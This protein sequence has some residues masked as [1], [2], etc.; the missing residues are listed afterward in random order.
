MEFRTCNERYWAVRSGIFD[1][2][3]GLTLT[4]SKV[5]AKSII[6]LWI[7][8]TRLYVRGTKP[9]I[10]T[11]TGQ[12]SNTSKSSMIWQHC[13]DNLTNQDSFDQVHL[14]PVCKVLKITQGAMSTTSSA[15][16]KA[17]CPNEFCRRFK[18]VKLIEVLPPRCFSWNKVMLSWILTPSC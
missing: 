9:E 2:L 14:T 11:W 8:A 16:Q 15:P 17:L 13:Y 12:N 5:E 4:S 3:S 1:R 7:S 18:G 6:A 10:T